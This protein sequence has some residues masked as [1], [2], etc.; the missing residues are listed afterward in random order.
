MR[1]SNDYEKD[2]VPQRA[3]LM[4][5]LQIRDSLDWA[6]Q[7][8]VYHVE[9]GLLCGLNGRN[10]TRLLPVVILMSSNEDRD[11]LDGYGLGATTTCASPL[12]LASSLMQFGISDVIG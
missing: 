8:L 12:T 4:Q 1:R 11:R 6:G 5:T 10:H 2:L 3:K 7:M 9:F